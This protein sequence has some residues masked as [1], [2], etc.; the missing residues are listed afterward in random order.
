MAH[1]AKHNNM[2]RPKKQLVHEASR[3]ALSMTV[4]WI[5]LVPHDTGSLIECRL[6]RARRALS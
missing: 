1:H 4:P 6:L 3:Q 2:F 5:L